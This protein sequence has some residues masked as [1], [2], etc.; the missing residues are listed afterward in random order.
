M[1]MCEK[2]SSY[3]YG[4]ESKMHREISFPR[5][6]CNVIQSAEHNTVMMQMD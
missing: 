3:I 5:N 2:V 6:V 1:Q 4:N